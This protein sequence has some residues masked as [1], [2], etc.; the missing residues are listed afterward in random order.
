MD[1]NFLC[2]HL[3][4]LSPIPTAGPCILPSLAS[5]ALTNL[6]SAVSAST[7]PRIVPPPAEKGPSKEEGRNQPPGMAPGGEESISCRLT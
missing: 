2:F 4:C 6:P 3:R 7:A 5:L 1:L